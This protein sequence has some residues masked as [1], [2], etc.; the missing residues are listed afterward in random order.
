M[1]MRV[2]NAWAAVTLAAML[3]MTA[4]CRVDEH[5]SGNGNDNVDISTPFGGMSVKTD[6]DA[7]AGQ[8]GID[9]YPGAKLVKKEKDKEGDHDSGAADI[10]FSFGKFSLKVKAASYQTPD[11]PEKVKVFYKKALAK[12][13]VV[14]ECRNDQPV[15]KPDV[16]PDGL[17]CEHDKNNH[18]HVDEDETGKLELKA[19]SKLHQHIVAID[20]KD[21]GTK[22][23][24]VALDLPGHLDIGDN[25]DDSDKKG[26]HKQ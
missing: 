22:F 11:A 24:L 19:G 26:E 3:G 21:G 12:Y 16:T 7:V 15:G 23:G 10:N 20:A 4:G 13:G 8:T 5:K 18:V 6:P 1:R 14:I 9:V 25:S 17:T 2:Q